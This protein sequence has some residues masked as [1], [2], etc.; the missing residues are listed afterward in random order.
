PGNTK[1][2]TG[3]LLHILNDG[4]HDPLIPVGAAMKLEFSKGDD[5]IE[6]IA[7]DA[8]GRYVLAGTA[9]NQEYLFV[10]RLLPNGTPDTLF[11]DRGVMGVKIK[12]PA[13]TG[14]IAGVALQ[15]D[16]RILVA[17]NQK[18]GTTTY[19]FVFRLSP[20]G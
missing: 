9:L 14:S 3:I 16:G 11:G 1:K 17:A 12:A 18:V 7:L 10:S 2:R 5:A 15:R 6:T 13:L 8:Q 4:S 19:G 20:D